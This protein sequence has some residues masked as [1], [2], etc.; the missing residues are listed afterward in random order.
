MTIH[1]P[2]SHRFGKALV[3]VDD[4]KA[5]KVSVWYADED[6]PRKRFSGDTAYDDAMNFALD[7]A[8]DEDFIMPSNESIAIALGG[9]PADDDSDY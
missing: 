3:S 7:L 9:I 2:T 6:T 8:D 5:T 4:R 1:Y